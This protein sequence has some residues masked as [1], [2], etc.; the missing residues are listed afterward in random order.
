[1]EK[2]VGVDQERYNQLE[3]QRKAIDDAR[4]VQ[5]E[6]MA[7]EREERVAANTVEAALAR[8][9]AEKKASEDAREAKKQALMERAGTALESQQ[10]MFNR[11]NLQR[12][13]SAPQPT[14]KTVVNR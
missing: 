5:T 7:K 6:Q 10:L 11:E 3:A 4:Q 1:M 2:T 8:I 13:N 12:P 9:E 14:P